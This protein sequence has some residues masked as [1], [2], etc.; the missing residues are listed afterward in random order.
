[1]R[2][3]RFHEIQARNVR[4]VSLKSGIGKVRYLP[5]SSAPGDGIL[6]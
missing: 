5:S 6:L 3:K 1:L 4:A 2:V